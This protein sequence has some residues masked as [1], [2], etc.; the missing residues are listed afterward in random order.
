MFTLDFLKS[1]QMKD[2]RF[3]AVTRKLRSEDYERL[4]STRKENRR[5]SLR[6]SC[7]S[8]LVLFLP[9]TWPCLC[10]E[11]NRGLEYYIECGHLNKTVE[12]FV[13]GV[14]YKSMNHYM[15]SDVNLMEGIRRVD[16]DCCTIRNDVCTLTGTVQNWVPDRSN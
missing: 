4:E 9:C 12:V 2:V 3:V 15:N 16:I 5:N 1:S 7:C 14:E 11:L 8:M 10:F 13:N 6:R